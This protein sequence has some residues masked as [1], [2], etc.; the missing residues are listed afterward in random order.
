[1]T[2]VTVTHLEMT[3]PEQLLGPKR[4]CT[5]DYSLVQAEIPCPE[6]SRFL[7]TA[8]GSKWMWHSRLSWDYARWM[9]YLDRPDVETWVATV[10]GTPAGY[11]ELERQN[12]GS[13]ELV[14]FGV[15]PGFI[16]QGLGGA[17]LTDAVNRAWNIGAKRVWMH[18]CSLDHP[19]AID[20]YKARGFSPFKVT[21]EHEELPDKPP[22]PWPGANRLSVQRG[23]ANH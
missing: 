4:E 20:N 17:L 9:A 2:E 7:Y 14:Y 5:C 10:R 11:F 23:T 6:Y 12:K 19:H 3:A 18:T 16:G 21:V 8:V 13:V 22:E 1:M 15:V